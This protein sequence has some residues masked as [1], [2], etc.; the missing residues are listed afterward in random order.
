MRADRQTPV[1]VCD[2]APITQDQ[3]V[4]L[5]INSLLREQ[6]FL[7]KCA[8]LSVRFFVDAV[9]NLCK[10]VIEKGVLARSEV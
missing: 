7:F 3:H 9:Q 2:S 6:Y 4:C 1:F 5:D 10:L 8:A